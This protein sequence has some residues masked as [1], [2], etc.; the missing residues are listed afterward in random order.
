MEL[1][2]PVI[3]IYTDGSCKSRMGGWA[4]VLIWNGQQWNLC[5]SAYDTTSNRMELTAVIMALSKLTTRCIVHLYSDSKY[6]LDGIDYSKRWAKKHWKTKGQ[7]IPNL[8]LWLQLLDLL[9]RHVVY[10]HWVKG[11]VG[12]VYNEVCDS[13]A[14]CARINQI[15]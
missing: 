1:P 6:V 13:L 2:L 10:R 3:T 12:N 14:C 5:G 7:D 4:S 11:H 8:D 9:K 15:V